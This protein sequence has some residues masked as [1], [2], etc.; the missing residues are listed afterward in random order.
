MN[1]AWAIADL[2]LG[3]KNLLNWVGELR[4]GDDVDTHNEWLIN[5]INSV[6]RKKDTLYIL[7]DIAWNNTY[8]EL[9]GELRGFKKF[10]LGNHDKMLVTNYMRY[11]TVLPGLTT[12]K[13]YWLSHAPIHPQELRGRRNVH[14]HVHANSIED[15]R[16]INAS[17]EA[18]YGVPI[19]LS[20]M[21]TKENQDD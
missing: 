2:H 19:N 16:Y 17:V 15:D 7:G 13:N 3:H 8:L 12:H 9:V 1:T 21:L 4:G 14:G 6:V 20:L 5:Q 11:G 18:V 10:V